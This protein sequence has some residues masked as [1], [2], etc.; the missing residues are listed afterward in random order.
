MATS[1]AF[2]Y[3]HGHVP[4]EVYE[5]H[6]LPPDLDMYGDEVRREAG[7]DL[8]PHQ[9]SKPPFH[10]V[11][12]KLRLE[13]QEKYHS[14]KLVQLKEQNDEILQLLRDNTLCEK[15]ILDQLVPATDGAAL[16]LADAEMKHF[17][18]PTC[19]LLKAFIWARKWG[20]K[21]DR[22]WQF[23]KKG[24]VDEALNGVRTLLKV[25]FDKKDSPIF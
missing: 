3:D 5:T 7:I 6:G 1:V 11:Q 4:D 10:E 21:K 14:K 15:A 17:L 20:G 9:R 23:P 12:I 22:N 13:S 2:E 16:S 25:A 8:E 24:K 19:P 18:K